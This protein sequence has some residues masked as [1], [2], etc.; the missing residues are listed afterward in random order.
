MSDTASRSAFSLGKKRNSRGTPARHQGDS[1]PGQVSQAPKP[2]G[3]L[4]PA[5]FCGFEASVPLS[6]AIGLGQRDTSH[7]ERDTAWDSSGTVDIGPAEGMDRGLSAADYHAPAARHTGDDLDMA[8]GCCRRAAD[9]LGETTRRT[10]L[11]HR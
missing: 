2:V 6:H 5:D 4:Q 7:S 9:P 8:T 11:E 3:H 1:A 10:R